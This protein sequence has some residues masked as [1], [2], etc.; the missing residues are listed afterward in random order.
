MVSEM[1][2]EQP[3][4]ELYDHIISLFGGLFIGAVAWAVS[5]AGVVF[6]KS[7]SSTG[8]NLLEVLDGMKMVPPPGIDLTFVGI[9]LPEMPESV[10]IDMTML[11]VPILIGLVVASISYRKVLNLE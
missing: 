10:M 5:V 8:V 9:K 11:W 7:A 2:E 1:Q 4:V 3:K 6:I